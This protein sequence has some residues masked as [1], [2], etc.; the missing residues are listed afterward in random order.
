MAI[1]YRTQ[2][3]YAVGINME[4]NTAL[5]TYTVEQIKTLSRTDFSRAVEQTTLA[6]SGDPIFGYLFKGPKELSHLIAVS[7]KYYLKTGLV[8]CCYDEKQCI[9]GIS[10]WNEPDGKAITA[11]SAVTSGMLPDYFKLFFSVSKGSFYRMLNLSGCLQKNHWKPPHYYLFLIAAFHPGVGSALMENAISRF[12]KHEFYLE[13]SNPVKNNYFYGKHGFEAMPEITW[14]GCTV[15]P[16]IR[17][18]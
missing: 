12:G 14:K 13:N 17:K 1:T 6:F 18:S 5:Q 9:C 3:C 4:R 2:I 16:M 8:F 15:Q 7:L 10:M 11:S